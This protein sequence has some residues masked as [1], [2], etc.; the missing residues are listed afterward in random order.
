MG[1]VGGDLCMNPCILEKW[2]GEEIFRGEHRVGKCNG[3]RKEKPRGDEHTATH[4]N[5]LQHTLQHA[6]THC[7][8]LQ[9]CLYIR[10]S[11]EVMSTLQHT[12]THT[13]THCNTLQHSATLFVY[14]G[15]P[16]G[17][18]HTATHCNTRCNTLQHTATLCNTV[19]IYGNASK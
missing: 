8:T 12:A 7:N 2:G 17:D 4:C 16:R 11:L 19:Y 6:A 3:A 10:E 18:E 9:H 1:G 5:T 14:T 13:A 15:K